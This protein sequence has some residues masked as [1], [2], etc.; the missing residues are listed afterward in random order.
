MDYDRDYYRLNAQDGDRPALK[1]YDR[2]W[3]RYVGQAPVLE[4]GCGVGHFA[5]R[6][7]RHSDVFGLEGNSF[8]I[9]QLKIVA[10]RVKVITET[11]DLS[12]HSVGSIVALHV[13]EHISD[14]DLVLIGA[15]FKRILRPKGRML[16]VMP[17]LS[18]KAHALKGKRWSAFSDST[19]INLKSASDW[20]NLF[21]VQWNF[22]VTKTFSDGFYD[23]PYGTNRFVSGP[24]DAQRAFRTLV[25]WLAARPILRRGDGE[26]VVF[27]LE[28]I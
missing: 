23:F 25:Q 15:E 6:L 17:D 12:D 26:N 27:I 7:S 2:L 24:G 9:E 22:K 21:E 8:A 19:H 20:Q 11:K 16:V 5:N 18:G 14:A 1:M 3:R 13:L 10:P 4:F 28:A